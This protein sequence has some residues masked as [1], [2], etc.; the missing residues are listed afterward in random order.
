VQQDSVESLQ[1]DRETSEEVSSIFITGRHRSD[2]EWSCGPN[3]IEELHSWFVNWTHSFQCYRLEV[4]IS[5]C[6]D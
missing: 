6:K 5:L 1:N 4:S 2:P 3:H